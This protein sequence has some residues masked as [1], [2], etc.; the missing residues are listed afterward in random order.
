MPDSGGTKEKFNII[1]GKLYATIAMHK[2]YFPELVTIERFLDVNMPVSGSDK[3]YLERLD[4]LCSY[5]HELSVSSY[6][7]RHLHHNLCA[8]VD[9]LKNNSFTFIQEEYYIVL[10]K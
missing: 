1:V 7:I 9:A 4:E 10:P 2:A 5:L 6:L 3:D 8:D